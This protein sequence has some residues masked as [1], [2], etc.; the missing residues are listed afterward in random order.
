MPISES[1][2][3][4]MRRLGA[5]KEIAHAEVAAAHRALP[6]AERLRR[7]WQLS[8]SRPATARAPARDDDPERFYALARARGLY[9]P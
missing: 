3:A 1:E 8:L 5:Y 4:Y 7:S 2:R 6:L 9:R